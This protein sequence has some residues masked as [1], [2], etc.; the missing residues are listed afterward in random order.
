M[1]SI[2]VSGVVRARQAQR[3]LLEGG[4]VPAG[5]LPEPI[6]ASWRRCLAL[7]LSPG[8][9][10]NI[11]PARR[12][13][14]AEARERNSRLLAK[15][16]P[17]IEVLYDQ[18]VDTQSM[19]VLADAGG[20]ILHS[21]GDNRFLERAKRVALE[22]GVEWSE[23]GKGTNAIGTALAGRVPVVV[24]GPQHYLAA[25]DFL[26][27][28]AAPILDPL[29]EPIGV[30]DVT[31]DWRGF[32]RHTL[33]LVKMSVQLI[34]NDLFAGAFP[35]GITLCFHGRAEFVGTLCEGIAVFAPEGTLLSANRSACFQFGAP[36]EAV[37]GRRFEEMFNGAFGALLHRSTLQGE[38]VIPLALRSG[39]KVH[40]RVRSARAPRSASTQD[41]KAIT[42][43]AIERA[44]AQHAGNVSAAARELRISRTTLYRKLKDR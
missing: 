16:L 43:R 1:D 33:S 4:G 19:I 6:E 22:P 28:S 2:G 29:G 13:R 35:D 18:I 34:E 20:F 3:A 7:G 10:Q 26:T 17:V 36:L 15:A 24:H 11:D 32:D 40:A 27:C 14:L 38:A 8:A 42:H 44:L 21:L 37:R 39:V 41:L 25:N 5:I 31:G 23:A 30:L 9:R 12:A